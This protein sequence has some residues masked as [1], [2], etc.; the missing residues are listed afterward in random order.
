MAE[1]LIEDNGKLLTTHVALYP[2]YHMPFAFSRHGPA[3]HDETLMDGSIH[4]PQAE[5][6]TAVD[7]CTD[8]LCQRSKENSSL[9][10]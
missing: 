8:G 10:S 9:A 3:L 4:K 7:T 5:I 2:T 1:G 6:I